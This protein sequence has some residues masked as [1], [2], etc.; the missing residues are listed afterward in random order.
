MV[1]LLLILL[2]DTEGKQSVK[3]QYEGVKHQHQGKSQS[4]LSES[5]VG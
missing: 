1:K 3:Q 5:V 2:C 4:R